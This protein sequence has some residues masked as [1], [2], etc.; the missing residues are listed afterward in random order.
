MNIFGWRV[1]KSSIGIV[2]AMYL[3]RFFNLSYAAS[4]GLIAIL[5]IQATKRQTYETSKRRIISVFIGLSLSALIF[6]VFGFEI[7]S[8][9]IFLIIFLPILNRLKL[10]DGLMINMVLVTH[11]L[12]FGDISLAILFNEIM[13][14]SIGIVTGIILNIHM[15]SK[16]N[17]IKSQQILIEYYMRKILYIYSLELKNTCYLGSDEVDI[18]KTLKSAI[19]EGQKLAY[20]HLENNFFET[21]QIYVSYMS[22]RKKQLFLLES[23]KRHIGGTILSQEVA[24]EI[25]GL[26]Q[27]VA[28]DLDIRKLD[29]KAL[30]ELT[31]ILEK[32]R[33]S[34][35]PATRQGF[36]DRARLF[37]FI[38]DLNEFLKLKQEF[39]NEYNNKA[40][41]K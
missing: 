36:E 8:L 13:L 37:L 34:P 33:K 27:H 25:S 16:E 20:Q 41:E 30:K 3:A 18:L 7:Y 21:S 39:L 26:T 5:S 9:G 29:T 10:Q 6:K 22:M 28:R 4:A 11:I 14:F 35:L 12:D 15:P 38:S 32:Y 1:I 40:M 2:L 24:E 17:K 23:M 31:S 19:K